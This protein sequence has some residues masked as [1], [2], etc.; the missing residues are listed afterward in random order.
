MNQ[1]A[2][3]ITW[4][5]W[6]M[7][8]EPRTLRPKFTEDL[9]LEKNYILEKKYGAVSLLSPHTVSIEEET[10]RHGQYI[11]RRSRV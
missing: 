4:L 3:E 7:P 5:S 11:M 8:P 1:G 6:R 10:K 2:A 9:H